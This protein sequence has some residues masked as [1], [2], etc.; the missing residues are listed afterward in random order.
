ML[1]TRVQSPDWEDLLE[2]GMAMHSRILAW[3]I[4]WTKETGRLQSVGSQ[5]QTGLRDWLPLLLLRQS[6]HLTIF[7]SSTWLDMRFMLLFSCI[8]IW[9]D[10]SSWDITLPCG[11]IFFLLWYFFRIFWKFCSNE[12]KLPSPMSLKLSSLWLQFWSVFSTI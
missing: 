10:I 6:I 8:L 12:Y 4:P 1:E 2:E 3:R 9:N 7:N 11:I 5:S